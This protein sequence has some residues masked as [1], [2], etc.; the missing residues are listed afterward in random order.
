MWF[1]VGETGESMSVAATLL[2]LV[3]DVFVYVIDD[4]GCDIPVHIGS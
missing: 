2:V 4:W 3:F 1:V